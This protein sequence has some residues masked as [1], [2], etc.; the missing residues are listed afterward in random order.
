MGDIRFGRGRRS[1][2]ATIAISVVAAAAC[3]AI[4][5]STALASPPPTWTAPVP[6]DQGHSLTAVSCPTLTLC[7]AIDNVGNVV[8]SAAPA[9]ATPGWQVNLTAGLLSPT[10]ISCPQAAFCVATV[11]GGKIA[12]AASPSG[13][14]TSTLIDPPT[15]TPVHTLTGVS[16]PTSALCVAVDDHGNLLSSTN[17]TAGAPA[18]SPPGSIDTT[19]AINAISCPTTTFCAAVDAKNQVLTSTDPTTASSWKS[20]LL[21]T[22][23]TAISCNA[24]TAC[25]A[26]DA[27]GNAY[28]TANAGT[29]PVTWSTTP[30]E[31]SQSTNVPKSVSCTD[32][33]LCVIVDDHGNAITS[34]NFTAARPTWTAAAIDTNPLTGVSCLVAGFCVAVD[35]NGQ[36]VA[37]TSPLGSATTGTGTASDQTDATLTATIDPGDAA[38]TACVFVFGTSTAYGGVAPCATTP[39]PGGGPQAVSAQISGLTASTTYHFAIEVTTGVAALDGADATLTTPAPLKANPSLA[40]TPAVGSTLTCKPNVTTTAAETVAFQWLSDTVPIANANA[41]TYAVQQTDATHHLSCQVTI[42]G[43]GGSATAVSGFNAI[44]NTVGLKVSESVVGTAKDSA[45]GS[46]SAPVTCSSLA[47]GSCTFTLTL[48]TPQIVNH[49]R[50]KVTIGSTT[51]KVAIGATKT[52][53]V[54]LNAAGRNLL[55]RKHRLAA[56]FTVA[57]TLLGTL[58]APLQTDKFTFTAAKAK[59][60]HATRHTKAA[61]HATRRPR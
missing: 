43:D 29:P 21:A 24:A 60:K 32:S 12:S 13:M 44:P 19:T 1:G 22:S 6:A 46:V 28:A 48:T 15:G 57:G 18:W 34:D 52:L 14:W 26:V 55:A 53:T 36:A 40:G 56:T 37:G 16:C 25:V 35:A 47:A 39:A 49:K 33:G 42:A 2:R 38:V 5:A 30:V 61:R 10:S 20:T 58:T 3:A 45:R 27:T 8:T 23:A 41:S 54:V 50:K 9:S 7:A 17:P 51:A 31:P 59:K 11:S 4:L